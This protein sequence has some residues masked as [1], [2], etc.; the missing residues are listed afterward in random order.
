ME[1]LLEKWDTAGCRLRYLNCGFVMAQ[2][3]AKLIGM[4][5][6]A[7]DREATDRSAALYQKA[8]RWY[9]ACIDTAQALGTTAM[10]G[11]TFLE[12]GD[13]YLTVDN[14]DDAKG[15]YQKSIALFE[16]SDA[17]MYL[18]HARVKLEK[19]NKNHFR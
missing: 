3:Y 7:P 11:R 1:Q 9:R 19:L 6:Q 16:Q 8:L 4:T 5:G 10:Q 17:G 15:A 12:L 18:Q 14:P 2:V 13:L